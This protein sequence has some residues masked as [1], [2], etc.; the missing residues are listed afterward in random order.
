MAEGNRTEVTVRSELLKIVEDLKKIAE[1][2][3]QVGEGF[4]KTGEEVGNSTTEQTKR[5]QTAMDRM[6]GFG[7]RVAD[8]LK[9]DFRS[10]LSISALGESMKLT[11]QFRGSIRETISLSDTIRKLGGVFGVAKK[12]FADFQGKLTKGMGDIGLSSESAARAL[13][14]LSQSGAPVAGQASVGG[15][16]RT[17]GML[18]STT[19]NQGRE[20]DIARL[21]AQVIQA[22]GGNVNDL[23]QI[24]AVAEDVR[25]VFNATGTGAEQTLNA[26]KS[27]FTNM[28][29][30]FRQKITT[31]GLANL[32]A[33]ATMAG[34]NSTKFL[35]EFLGK[36]PIARKAMEAQGF[37]GVISD[38]G[39]DVE[40]FREASKAVLG[41]IGMDPRKA[42]QTL[43]LSEEAAEGFLRLAE[44][45]DR[46]KAAQESVNS[47]TGDLESQYRGSQTM[48]EA[49]RGSINR[50]K[51]LLSA[52]LGA[53]TQK[54]TDLL[55]EASQSDLGSAAVVGAGATA[56]ALLAG[57]GLRGVGKGLGGVAKGAA[58]E[59]AT[60]RQVQPVYVV[61]ASEIGSGGV[62]AAAG[63]MGMA[64]KAAGVLGKAGGVLGAGV[65]GYEVGEALNSVIESKTQGVTQEGF[66]GNAIERLIFKLD[67]LVGGDAAK[68]VVAAEQKVRVELNPKEL[69]EA[70]RPGRGG[71]N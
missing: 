4:K 23:K 46:V 25:R 20:S 69:R 16:A 50:V 29:K 45:L 60:G 17:A 3:Q 10:M 18:A 44:S 58:V 51:G 24:G 48:G 52:P 14:G 7:R 56:A 47:A 28:S 43:G 67:Q 36:S 15:Y 13:E 12:D 30:D 2:Q 53:V 70:K 54:G 31:R 22:R 57:F 5:V 68:R 6:R 38:K 1:A 42:A 27:I 19:R 71:G 35:E 33:T 39:L 34:P 40:K 59:A 37:G 55:S 63:A 21:I 8:Q 49:F 65:A 11:E 41:R 32:A 62:G 26:M 9:S 66:Q 64:G 61:N